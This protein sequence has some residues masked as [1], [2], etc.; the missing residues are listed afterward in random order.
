M[1]PNMGAGLVGGSE[2][3]RRK[4]SLPSKL[5]AERILPNM[6]ILSTDW[7]TIDGGLY[8]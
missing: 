8:C 7:V 5:E 3:K 2:V 6:N 1:S 4:R